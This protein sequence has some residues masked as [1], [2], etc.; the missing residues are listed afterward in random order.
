[1]N[2][3][4]IVRQQKGAETVQDRCLSWFA[5]VCYAHSQMF[6][7]SAGCLK[8]HLTVFYIWLHYKPICFSGVPHKTSQKGGFWASY[9]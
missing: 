4:K 1:M 9:N 5:S 6:K 3:N 2:T 7:C 8:C